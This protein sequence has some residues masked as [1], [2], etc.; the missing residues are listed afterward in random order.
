MNS[1]GGFAQSLTQ[2]KNSRNQH[3]QEKE[4]ES[5]EELAAFANGGEEWTAS[6]S[7][8]DLM[9]RRIHVPNLRGGVIRCQVFDWL[10]F[11][12]CTVVGGKVAA[13][14]KGELLVMLN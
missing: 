9:Q 3:S 2:C 13:E 5:D 10:D 1:A 6:S 4:R 8:P 11:A 14:G 12:R 7:L